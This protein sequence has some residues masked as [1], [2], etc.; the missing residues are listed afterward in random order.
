MLYMQISLKNKFWECFHDEHGNNEFLVG[1][2][3]FN[4]W[5]EKQ[6]TVT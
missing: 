2:D 6:F 4:S 1:N 5:Q 3:S